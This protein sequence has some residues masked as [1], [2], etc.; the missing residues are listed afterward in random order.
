MQKTIFNKKWSERSTIEKIG[1]VGGGLT[2]VL[3]G[4]NIYKKYKAGL[5]L[6][7]YREAVATEEEQLIQAGKK[8]TY[9]VSNYFTFADQLEQA[10]Q[11]AMTYENVI[12]SIFGKMRN[13][14]DILQSV[15]KTKNLYFRICI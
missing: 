3:I 11:Y 8:L 7:L 2:V 15:G 5:N 1:I 6:K 9:P 14:L 10:M 4:R 13:D 12:Y